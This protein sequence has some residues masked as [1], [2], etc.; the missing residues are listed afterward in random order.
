M[1]ILFVTPELAPF[2]KVG[3]LADVV[4]ALPKVF[5]EQGHE[6]R[7]VCPFYGSIRADDT[8]T[9]YQDPLAVQ[10]GKENKFARVWETKLPGSKATVYFLEHNQYFHRHEIYTGPWG[11]HSDN[12]ERFIFLTRASLDLCYYLNWFP[13]VIHAHDWPTALLPIMLNTTD[14]NGP[15]GGTASVLT[16]HNLEHQGVFPPH[17]LEFAHLPGWV[18]RPDGLESL[19]WVN[20]LKGGI[21]HA[22]K[23]TTVSP[24]YAREIQQPI[25]GCG[26]DDVLRFKSGDLLGILNG[27][28]HSVW[29]PATDPLLPAHYS[30][31]DLSGKAVCKQ[32]LQKEFQLDVDPTIPIFGVISRLAH[33]KGL[34]L[35]ETIL[36]GVFANMRVQVVVLGAGEDRLQWAYGE[37]PSRYPGRCGSYIGF[38]NRLAHL[39]EAGS[40]FFLMP[41]RFEPCG[42]NQLYSMAYGTP[43]LVRATGGLVDSVTQYVE[44]GNSGTGFIFDE[45]TAHALYFTIGWACATYYDRPEELL[46]L[47][48]R[49]MQQDFSWEKSAAIYLNVYDWAI[50]A[51]RS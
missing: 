15:L 1:K 43:P 30:A 6:V 45:P 21:F 42:L 40:D 33:Q 32:L 25:G 41:S 13:D 19:G 22:N 35:L 37:M 38:N 11:S 29:N 28:D 17:A 50:Q 36:P 39:I 27:I 20:S 51:R 10:V 44:G 24:H 23:I 47:R 4:G 8:F 31:D 26:L 7:I 16:I 9:P 46:A 14:R 12:D 49:G 5:A 2:V 48:R 3:G 18:F 34:D